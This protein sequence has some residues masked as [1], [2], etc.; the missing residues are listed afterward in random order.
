MPLWLSSLLGAFAL[1]IV[2]NLI[3][4]KGLGLEQFDFRQVLG[5]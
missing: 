1:P 5:T 4:D 2:V 3:S